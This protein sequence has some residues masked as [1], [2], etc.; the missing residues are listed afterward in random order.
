MRPTMP[1][2]RTLTL[3]REMVRYRVSNEVMGGHPLIKS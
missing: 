3:R 2:S 1:A